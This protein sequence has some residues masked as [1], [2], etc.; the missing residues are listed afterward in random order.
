MFI[1][2]YTRKNWVYF[3]SHKNESLDVFKIFKSFVEKEIG[4][5]IKCLRSDRGGEF[6][7]N[8]FNMFYE[9]KGIERQLP[10]TYTPQQNGV[11]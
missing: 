5:N 3:V 7:S 1:D 9:S 2:D 8:P 10:A 6:T 11:A 4:M